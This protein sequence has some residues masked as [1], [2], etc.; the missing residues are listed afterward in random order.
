[1]IFVPLKETLNNWAKKK[2]FS[3]F[4]KPEKI[5]QED[6]KKKTRKKKKNKTNYL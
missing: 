3:Y 1:M 5:Q 4:V 2:K 6:S